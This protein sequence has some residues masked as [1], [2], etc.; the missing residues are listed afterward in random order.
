MP[1]TSSAQPSPP[2]HARSPHP[3]TV[4]V[5]AGICAAL[6]VGKLPPAIQVLQAQL[7][8]TLVQ[9]GFLLSTVQVAGMLLG[10]AV[11]LS[12][13]RVGLR[14]S[15]VCGLLL[16]AM[17]S[18]LGA[19]ATTVGWLL[20]LRAVEGLG[21]LLVVMPGPSLIRRS[22][23]PYELG[24]RMGWWG[25]YM[26]LGSALGLLLGPWVLQALGWPRW[27]LMAAALSV[28]AALAVWRW[29]PADAPVA[30]APSADSSWRARLALTLRS[31]GPWLVAGSFAVYSAQWMG[32]V[33]FLPAMYGEAG[34]SAQVAGTLT[35]LVAAA[36]MLGNVASG[37]LLARGFMVRQCLQIGFIGM[38]LCA[39]LAFGQWGS[40]GLPLA[41]RFAAVF[42]FSAVGGLIPATLFTCAV[43]LAPSTQTVSTTVGFMQQLSCIGQ[44][45]GPPLVAALATA[46]GG[47]Q[48]TWSLTG[49]LC[50]IGLVLAGLVQ[51]QWRRLQS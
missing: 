22:V 16:L 7:G 35:A 18:A 5:A 23:P 34:L 2:G 45:V 10:L 15:M 1:V 29:V 4:V 50:V 37:Q 36:N 20:G 11:G 8:V 25:S 9:A 51:L 46:V 48:W 38:G 40:A 17:A 14:R 41:L 44:F 30:A 21:F 33:G 31:A 42:G 39:L 6:H 47:W 43:H 13:D 26:P 28:L 24:K 49:S 27:W 12:A 19:S 3:A 32:V